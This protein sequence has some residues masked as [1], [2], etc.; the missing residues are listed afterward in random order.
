M[1]M[2]NQEKKNIAIPLFM[3]FAILVLGIVIPVIVNLL[4]I[5]LVNGDEWRERADA[6]TMARLSAEPFSPVTEK[7]WRRPFLFTTFTSIGEKKQL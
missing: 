4:K 3:V 2:D 6:K 7:F 5:Q 1:K